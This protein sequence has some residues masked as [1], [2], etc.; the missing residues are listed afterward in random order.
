MTS[1]QGD[2]FQDDEQNDLFG[3]DA[4]TPTYRADPE[5]VRAELHRILAEV[6][7]RTSSPGSHARLRFIAP[8]SRK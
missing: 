3:E 4:P 5:E 1:R 2:L 7:E 6:R 8:S